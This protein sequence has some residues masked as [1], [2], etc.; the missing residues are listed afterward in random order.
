MRVLAAGSLG[1]DATQLATAMRSLAQPRLLAGYR[2][3]I[4]STGSSF[5]NL[6]DGDATYSFFRNCA[7]LSLLSRKVARGH[8]LSC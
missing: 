3:F 5:Q 2:P 4:L 8:S 7:A 6:E 1:Y